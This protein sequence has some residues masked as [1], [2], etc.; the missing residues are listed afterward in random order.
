MESL[1]PTN[2]L[3]NSAAFGCK[4]HLL[5]I[6]LVLA[7]LTACG[8]S[9]PNAPEGQQD[10]LKAHQ[11]EVGYSESAMSYTDVVYVPIYS[12]MY[13]DAVHPSTLL[14]ATL[15]IRNTSASDSLFVSTID[16]YNTEGALVRSY[17]DGSIGLPPLGTINYVIERED[18]QGGPGANFLVALAGPAP[19]MRPLIQAVMVG[20]TGN[21][22]YAFA[23]DGYSLGAS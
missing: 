3:F 16:Y 22:G 8:P 19:N 6:A 21:K 7:G 18:D 11:L 15:S 13:V 10:K 17:I 23:C 1:A 9:N 14:A 12:D 4:P 20:H 2:F 5:L